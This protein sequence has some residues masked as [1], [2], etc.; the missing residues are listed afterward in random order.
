MASLDRILL[1]QKKKDFKFKDETEYDNN[2]TKACQVAVNFIRNNYDIIVN[3]LDGRN[4]DNFLEEFGLN[5]QR[6]LLS[7]FKKFK[8]SKGLGGLKLLRDLTEYKDTLKLFQR[9][10]IDDAFEVLCEIAKIHLVAAEN[11]KTVIEEG[12]LSRMDRSDLMNYIR[13][14]SDYKSVWIGKYV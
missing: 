2:P 11:L 14:R 8:V 4:V 13:L 1:D 7:H 5:F 12:P 10:A 9:Q 3:C 6:S